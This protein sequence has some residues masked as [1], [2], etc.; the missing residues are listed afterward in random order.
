MSILLFPVPD[1]LNGDKLAAEIVEAGFS[2][3]VS[4]GQP[5]PIVSVYSDDEGNPNYVQIIV[6]GL[7][8]HMPPAEM[9]TACTNR[10]DLN[11]LLWA[12]AEE[13]YNADSAYRTSIA[14]V[15][16]AHVGEE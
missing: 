4:E 16:S 10:D 14:A 6:D 1:V 11:W 2:P 7:T 12:Y 15:V 8:D 13:A 3:F 9:R 5:T